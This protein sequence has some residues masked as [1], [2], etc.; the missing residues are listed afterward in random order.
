MYL[1]FDFILNHKYFLFLIPASMIIIAKNHK[2]KKQRIFFYRTKHMLMYCI[3]NK[4]MNKKERK[5]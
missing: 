1:N 5:M 4:V 2:S 3:I